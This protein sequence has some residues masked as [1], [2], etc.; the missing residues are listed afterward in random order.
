MDTA[1]QLVASLL[2][3][4]LTLIQVPLAQGAMVS[5]AEAINVEQGDL[6]RDHLIALLEKEELKQQLAGYGLNASVAVE[7][8]NSM[9]DAEVALLNTRIDELPAGEGVVGIAAMIFIVFIITD[10]LGATDLFTFVKPINR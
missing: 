7:R 9:S 1:R 3:M 10:A 5:T 8:V 4:L 6:S 2:I